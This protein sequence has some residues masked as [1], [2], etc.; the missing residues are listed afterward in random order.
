[1]ED[2][3]Y[4][5]DGSVFSD[6][7]LDLSEGSYQMCQ[8]GRVTHVVQHVPVILICGTHAA[9]RV[10]HECHCASEWAAGGAARIIMTGTKINIST[11]SS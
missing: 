5:S 9:Q 8:M 3:L 6:G 11:L 10:G 1:M 7:S 2:T 4:L